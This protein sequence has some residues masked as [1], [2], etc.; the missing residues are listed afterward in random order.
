MAPCVVVAD[1]RVRGASSRIVDE[2][3]ARVGG[4]LHARGSIDQVAGDHSLPLRA[5]SDSCLAGRD[6]RAELQVRTRLV[7]ELRDCYHEIERGPYRPLRVVLTCH[8][9][10]PDCHYCVADELLDRAAVAAD[11][12][13]CHLEI[14]REEL[15][16]L[17]RVTGL[18]KRREADEV[19]K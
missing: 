17:L 7:T 4:R 11:Q 5:Q 8:R 16:N 9:S 12:R 6:T 15:T 13:P 10:T 14:P 19:G 2:H 1:R 3:R 18:R